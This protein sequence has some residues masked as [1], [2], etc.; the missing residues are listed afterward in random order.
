MRWIVRSSLK[1]R[2]L[3]VAAAGGLLFFGVTKL[4]HTPVDVFPEFAPPRVEIQTLAVGLTGDTTAG[5]ALRPLLQDRSSD[6]R[7]TAAYVVQILRGVPPGDLPIETPTHFEFVL[8]QKI[9]TE[10]GVRFDP[11]T[12]IR[13]DEVIE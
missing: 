6:V 5:P 8:N 7:R 12:L 1:F 4:F 3:L 13:A 10:L 2:F 9:A 11:A